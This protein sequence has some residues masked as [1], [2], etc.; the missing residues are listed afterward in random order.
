[1]SLIHPLSPAMRNPF[2]LKRWEP[3]ASSGA[4]TAG[5]DANLL[6]ETYVSRV[7]RHVAIR[8][9]RRDDAEDITADVFAAAFQSLSR[10]RCAADAYPWL[11][12]IARR[13]IA[14]HLRKHARP[15]IS[16]SQNSAILDASTS[17]P[18][19]HGGVERT[20]AISRMRAIVA[21]LGD[22]QRDALLMQY[23]DDLSVAEI[24]SV[25]KRSPAAVNS[26]LQRARAN[27]YQ[28][29]EPYFLATEVNK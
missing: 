12:G 15:H 9:D 25:M 4:A 19:P 17:L 2:K 29:G 6:Y 8:V 5:I 10:L 13:K 7:L 1:M 26:L 24:A 3:A 18:G 16:L 21:G 27:V 14:D 22:D 11:L 20:E 23:V 28:A